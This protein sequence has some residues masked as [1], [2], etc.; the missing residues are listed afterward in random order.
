MAENKPRTAREVH[1]DS[2]FQQYPS[3]PEVEPPSN[4]NLEA[5]V[6][7]QR[8]VAKK[9]GILKERSPIEWLEAALPIVGWLRKYNFKENIVSDITAGLTVAAVVVP[10]GI[11]YATLAGMP[12]EFGLYCSIVPVYA[13]SIFGTSRQAAVGTSALSSLTFQ[14]VAYPLV[15]PT[16]GPMTAE[17]TAQ[18][19]QLGIQLA[20]VIGLIYLGFGILQLGFINS[21]FS[22]AVMSGFITGTVV[23]IILSQLKYIL[24]IHIPGS[25]QVQVILKEIFTTLYEFNWK[26]FVIGCS[27]IIL[28]L[29]MEYLGHKYKKLNIIGSLGPITVCVITIF[30]S[31]ILDFENNDVPV[32]GT[33]ISGLPP[34]SINQW[35]PFNYDILSAA[36][37]IFIVSFIESIGTAQKFAAEHNYQVDC[38][39][40]FFALGTA[41]FFGSMVSIYPTV[42]SLC[43]TAVNNGAG[44]RSQVAAIIT[45]TG[46][47]VVLLALVFL[48]YYLP[49]CVLGAI[50]I[51]GV[52]Y[53]F[54]FGHFFF[55]W[56]VHK[57][58]CLT[59]CVSFLVTM[60]V[61]VLYGVLSAVLLSLL[62]IQYESAY[63][64]TSVMGRLP[65][66]TVYR[67]VK[68]YSEATQYPGIVLVRIDAPLYFA[69][70][71]Y[72]R[73]KL[74]KYIA[75][76]EKK[77]DEKVN[78]V[79]ADISAAAYI[80]STAMTI[81]SDMAKDYAKRGIQL[82]IC[83]PGRNILKTI[84]KAGI[85]EK[86][87]DN[88]FSSEH[89]AI[90]V[91]R[92]RLAEAKEGFP[93][94]N[95]ENGVQN[96]VEDSNVPVAE[97]G[98]S[99][100]SEGDEEDA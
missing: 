50:V 42:I 34:A 70:A 15:N 60:F 13:Y 71:Q 16:D 39:Q 31:W 14:S 22:K 38:S 92:G 48:F 51:A 45:A 10:Q 68:Q 89:H 54:E 94:T 52:L 61:S 37:T 86:L 75:A 2:T 90:S 29:I 57:L 74:E 12:V 28:I 11:S 81:F 99:N 84:A 5:A 80:D 85:T 4:P 27:S 49:M 41:N 46:V 55:L 62:I 65:N 53:S 78:Y 7:L 87:G 88:L 73:E 35:F 26:T 63:P 9:H 97:R 6:R 8:D 59:W 40:E 69:N 96:D 43:R 32:V 56:K 44:A 82:C 100:I 24:G 67:D 93:G 30:L 83:G 64:H 18:Y 91:C 23:V 36:I 76:S 58:D 79:I 25:N 77:T 95:V 66:S 17:L 72:I 21:F 33:I 19:A 3:V 1:F 20:F 98:M 47:I